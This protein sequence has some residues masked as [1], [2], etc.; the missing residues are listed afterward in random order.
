MNHMF[1]YCQNL[2]NLD[3]SSF[4]INKENNI[5]FAFYGCNK[6]E[7]LNLKFEERNEIHII[8]KV[9]KLDINQEIYFLDNTKNDYDSKNILHNHDNL[10][11]LNVFYTKVFINNEEY[12]SRKFFVPKKE[13]I[14]PIILKFDNISIKDCSYMFYSCENIIG[15]D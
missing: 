15:I 13:G 6:L 12:R 8:I 4:N 1:Y 3:L 7:D 2:I 14:Y 9:A 5:N 10:K 11:E